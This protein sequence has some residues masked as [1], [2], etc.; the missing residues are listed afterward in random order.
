MVDYIHYKG[1]QYPIRIAYSAAKRFK[2]E[3]K[4]DFDELLKDDL[5]ALEIILWYG[6]ISGHV[7]ENKELTLKRDEMEYIL[8]ESLEEFTRILSG[9]L[10]PIEV[11]QEDK[12]K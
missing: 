2:A 12:K 10:P 6:L 4:K 11:S 9:F 7:A 8:D 5:S 3:T 1:E